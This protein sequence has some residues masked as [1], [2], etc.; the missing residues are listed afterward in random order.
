MIP[1]APALRQV[2][3]DLGHACGQTQARHITSVEMFE[4]LSPAFLF[5]RDR[6]A[7]DHFGCAMA[8]GERVR[9]TL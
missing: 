8:G 7:T 6:R 4:R 1:L 5:E 3:I 2:A 9:R